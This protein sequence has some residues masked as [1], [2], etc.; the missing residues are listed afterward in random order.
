[1]AFPTRVGMIRSFTNHC[2]TFFRVPHACGDDPLD[3]AQ[4]EAEAERSPRVWG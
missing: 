3:I 2:R 1:M 4:A